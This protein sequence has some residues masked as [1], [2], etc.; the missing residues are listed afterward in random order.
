MTYMIILFVLYIDKTLE[1]YY[2]YQKRRTVLIHFLLKQE[3]KDDDLIILCSQGDR[4]AKKELYTKYAARLFTLCRRYTDNMEDAQDLMHDTFIKAFEKLS[5]YKHTGENS[6][7]SWL[8]RIAINSA[9]D[10]IKK[11][12]FRFESLISSMEDDF[13]EYEEK[14]TLI[15]SQEIL[16]EFISELPRTQ[17]TIF[18]MHCLDGYS[19][20][21]IAELLGIS[22][23]GSASMLAKAKNKLKE[24]IKEY[25][26]TVE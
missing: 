24:R 17:R 5:I 7:Y 19:H 20:K 26:R 14:N 15:V 8:R 23:K 3:T 25:I 21:E 22:E 12:K 2:T 1:K 4:Y 16:L 11:Y 9:L 18:N 6:F 13:V 10:N